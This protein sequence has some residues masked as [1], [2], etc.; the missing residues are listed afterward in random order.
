MSRGGKPPTRS[1]LISGISTL[2]Q[3]RTPATP[4]PLT[5][6]APSRHLHP[7]KE[8]SDDPSHRAFQAALLRSTVRTGLLLVFP[9]SDG[10]F[11]CLAHGLL[12]YVLHLV[13]HL[14]QTG[15]FRNLDGERYLYLHERLLLL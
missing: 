6:K 1:I 2:S 8:R 3:G 13:F 15:T 9:L 7:S 12:S 4:T 11:E 5:A 10:L 14:G